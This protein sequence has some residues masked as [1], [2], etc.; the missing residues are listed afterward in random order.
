MIDALKHVLLLLKLYVFYLT[1][2]LGLSNNEI[3]VFLSD[4]G[5]H[6][7]ENGMWG[8]GKTTE[9]ATRIPLIVKI[10]P[11]DKYDNTSTCTITGIKLNIA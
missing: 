11:G 7:G 8:K 4:H 6:V 1:F 5:V 9:L 3:V 2:I 10:V